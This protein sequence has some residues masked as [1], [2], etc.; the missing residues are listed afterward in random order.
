MNRK[1]TTKPTHEQKHSRVWLVIFLVTYGSIQFFCTI[2]NR[3]FFPFASYNMFNSVVKDKIVSLSVKI[4]RID[5]S[6]DFYP[7][8]RLL[9]IEFFVGKDRIRKLLGADASLKEA[10]FKKIMTRLNENPWMGF[11]EIPDP[12]PCDPKCVKIEIFYDL[13]LIQKYSVELFSQSP[14]YS[15]ERK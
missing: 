12:I 13:Y 2:S 10:E 6:S 8:E 4:S 7:V 15:Y 14:V 11:D 3:N 1:S 9:P 5:G